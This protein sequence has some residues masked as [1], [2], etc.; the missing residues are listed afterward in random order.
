MRAI[1][2][3]YYHRPNRTAVPVCKVTTEP[4]DAP[5]VFAYD[6]DRD[7]QGTDKV[8]AE[9]LVD[10]VRRQVR[11]EGS[12]WSPRSRTASRITLLELETQLRRCDGAD[13]FR[14]TVESATVA[15]RGSSEAYP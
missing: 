9:L 12:G 1:H 15:V 6:I 5:S 7:L 8:E 10:L 14:C 3:Y 13:P 11:R 4:S 2:T